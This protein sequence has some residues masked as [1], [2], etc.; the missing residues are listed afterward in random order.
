MKFYSRACQKP[1]NDKDKSHLTLIH[2]QLLCKQVGTNS[3][4]F[5]TSITCSNRIKIQREP[6]LNLGKTQR[7]SRKLS[8]SPC[9]CY[10]LTLK[11]QKISIN[12][13]SCEEDIRHSGVYLSNRCFSTS[14]IQYSAKQR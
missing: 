10:V 6:H 9:I 1:H 2:T 5:K 4:F 3:F 8:P 12:N 11:Q 14:E 13:I 7:C